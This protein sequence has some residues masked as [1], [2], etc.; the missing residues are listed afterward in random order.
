MDGNFS[1][2]MNLE[3]RR[4]E[5]ITKNIEDL[6]KSYV[7][8]KEEGGSAKFVL[9]FKNDRLETILSEKSVADFIKILITEYD[10][11]L[12][13]IKE[14]IDELFEDEMGRNFLHICMLE[15]DSVSEKE[16]RNTEYQ[17][18]NEEGDIIDK[19]LSFEEAIL[20]IDGTHG[21][22]YIMQPM[23]ESD[24]NDSGSL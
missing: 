8:F 14:E 4:C 1:R 9:H 18:K 11:I 2:I 19:N 16:K 7:Q 6:S 13:S 20:Y 3:L 17:I 24:Q 21:K 5:E 23:K 15:N 12:R 22:R 10:D